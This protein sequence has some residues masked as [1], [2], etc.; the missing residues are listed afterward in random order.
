MS[1]FDPIRA[2]R[3]KVQGLAEISKL[4]G[5]RADQAQR[6]YSEAEVELMQLKKLDAFAK[7]L[8]RQGRAE[9]QRMEQEAQ[10]GTS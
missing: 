6:A 8:L 1:V 4:T 9:L 3:E 10:G 7:D 5:E 2:M